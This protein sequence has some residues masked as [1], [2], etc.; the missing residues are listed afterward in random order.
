MTIALCTWNRAELLRNAL[1]SFTRLIVPTG[2]EWEVVVVDNNSTDQTKQVAAEFSSSLPIRYVFEPEQGLSRARNRAIREARGALVLFTDD[3]VVADSRWLA[4]YATEVDRHPEAAF[5]G[6]TI[7]VSFAV[8]P[9][10]WLTNNLDAFAGAFAIR[11][12]GHGV[13]R[14]RSREDL[15]YGANMAFRRHVLHDG[16]FATDLGRMGADLLS[17]EE[18]ELMERLLAQGEHGI[19]V[20]SARVEHVIGKDRLSRA[21]IY[22]YFFWHGRARARQ[23]ERIAASQTTRRLKKK[24]ARQKRSLR[25]SIIKNADWAKNLTALAILEGQLA[26]LSCS[27]ARGDVAMT[28]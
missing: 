8:E 23:D 24:I 4:E 17:G 1:G 11:R 26:E 21:Y 19:W 25:F 15:P 16:S 22:D 12:L 14:I 3:D 27:E 9:P 28:E 6:G 10:R 13:R 2:L 20:G 18:T 5:F 7:D